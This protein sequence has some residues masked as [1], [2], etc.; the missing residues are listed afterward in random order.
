M[1]KNIWE[2]EEPFRDGAPVMVNGQ[3]QEPETYTPAPDNTLSKARQE[4]IQQ[5]RQIQ[6]QQDQ[7]E[8]EYDVDELT[9]QV[10]EDE[11]S[12][13]SVLSDARLRLE[14]GRLYEMVINH[15][16]FNG[17]DADPRATKSVQNQIRKFAKEQ[18]EIM[19]GMRQESAQVTGIVS[20]PFNN[21]EVEVLKKIA[22]AASKG[23]TE[24]EEAQN[25]APQPVQAPKKTTLNA[26]GSS[27][28]KQQAKPQPK[29]IQKKVEPIQRKAQ[30]KPS[31]PPEMEPNYEP[32]SK[33]LHEMTA[34]ELAKRDQEALDRQRGRKAALPVDRA[35]MPDFAT[36]EM[37]ALQ[38]VS[39]ATSSTK[40]NLSGLIMANLRSSGKI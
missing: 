25:E 20:S 16:L 3:W 21:L 14:Q 27:K 13:E 2:D 23:A 7:D 22:S 37:I 5:A 15:D 28:P 31:L 4:Q 18:M 33:P 12:Y 35:P 24:S 38:Q 10:A 19:L 1:A 17:A 11:D 6:A 26:I 29:P 32:L 30:P 9:D 40:G 39:R 34:A 8:G 36:T